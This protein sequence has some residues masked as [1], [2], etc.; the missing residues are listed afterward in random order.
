MGLANSKRVKRPRYNMYIDH[1]KKGDIYE[2]GI[3]IYNQHNKVVFSDYSRI[4][5][6]DMRKFDKTL[7]ALEKG[8]QQ[9]RSKVT[10]QE[11]SEDI[12][13]YIYISTKTIYNWLAKGSCPKEYIDTFSNILFELSL[14]G[15]ET[16]IIYRDKNKTL[17]ESTE[18]EVERVTDMFEDYMG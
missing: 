4:W 8:L 17:F 10:N 15:N 7:I 12:P 6:E 1:V 14:L 16:E 18:E 11:L 5:K 9:F 2:R 3:T 13:L